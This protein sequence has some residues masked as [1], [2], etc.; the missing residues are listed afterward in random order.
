MKHECPLAN[1][2]FWFSDEAKATVDSC[3][4]RTLFTAEQVREWIEFMEINHSDVF[5]SMCVDDPV[6]G[7]KAWADRQEKHYLDPNDPTTEL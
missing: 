3:P 5:T 6:Y 4:C 2:G 1:G 7:I